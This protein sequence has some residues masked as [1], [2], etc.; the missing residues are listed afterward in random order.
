[1]RRSVKFFLISKLTF[2]KALTLT[3]ELTTISFVFLFI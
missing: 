1:M 2:D 3:N